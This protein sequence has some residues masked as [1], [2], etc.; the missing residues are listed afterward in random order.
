MNIESAL[1]KAKEEL[2]FVPDRDVDAAW[3]VCFVTGLSRGE[4]RFRGNEE[5][6]HE[7]ESRLDAL[8]ARRKQREPLQYIFGT[9]PFYNV[10]LKCDS[11]ALIP[12]DETA[13][14]AEEA[15]KIIKE[16]NFASVL[17]LCTGSGAIAA[18]IKYTCPEVSVSASDIS[19]DALALAKE[20]AKNLNCDIEFF[21]GDL[22]APLKGKNFD[23]IISNPPYIATKDMEKLERELSFEPQCALD[24]GADGLDFYRDIATEAREHINKNGVLIME[25]GFDEGDAIKAIL[26]RAGWGNIKCEKDYAG[27]DRVISCTF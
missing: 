7:Q 13:C 16:N 3:I 22:F 14:M 6:T 18:A 12:R 26:A 20:N 17:D 5:L 24:G 4:L 1:K 10:E 8:L 25:I 27:F 21:Q 9:V 2:K 15:I 11:R 19:P 23:L